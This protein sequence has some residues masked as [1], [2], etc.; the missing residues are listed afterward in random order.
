MK[1]LVSLLVLGA[2]ATSMY[3][4]TIYSHGNV[5]GIKK[6]ALLYETEYINHIKN[7]YEPKIPKFIN[8]YT[9]LIGV[10]N[11]EEGIL[12]L[13]Y[14]LDEKILVE[15]V[16]T[17]MPKEELPYSYL[18]S[19]Q[20]KKYFAHKLFKKNISKCKNKFKGQYVFKDKLQIQFN[21]YLGEEFYTSFYLNKPLCIKALNR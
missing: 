4:K 5:A 17:N 3:A 6:E 7:F 10:N 13:E 14:R 16:K 20:V 8:D 15:Q 12:V 19:E 21:Y 9:S 11:P 2:I 1:K 18:Y